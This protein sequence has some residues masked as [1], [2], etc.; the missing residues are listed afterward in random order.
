LPAARQAFAKALAEA[1]ADAAAK[2]ALA[3]VE[4]LERLDGAEAAAARADQPGAT[5]ED[6]MAAAD[7]EVASGDFAQGFN[8]LLSAMPKASPEDKERLRLRLLSLFEVAGGDE[9]AVAQA[10]RRLAGLIF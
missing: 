3:Q 7:L 8:R 4:L 1:P 5:L 6:S 9:P 2:A 10:R